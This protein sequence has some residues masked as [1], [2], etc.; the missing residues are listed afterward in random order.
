[1]DRTRN[2][3]MFL[4]MET[5][6]LNPIFNLISKLNHWPEPPPIESTPRI[7]IHSSGL[8][9]VPFQYTPHLTIRTLPTLPCAL[10]KFRFSPMHP[11]PYHLTSSLSFCHVFFGSR[12][13]AT[14]HLRM[15]MLHNIISQLTCY[16]PR[17]ASRPQT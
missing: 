17:R 2:R 1:M 11:I 14:Y 3:I 4:N 5:S 16:I 13:C 8:Q 9:L 15:R 12:L 10:L 6:P 7:P